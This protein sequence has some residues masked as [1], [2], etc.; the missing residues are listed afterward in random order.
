MERVPIESSK[1]PGAISSNYIFDPPTIIQIDGDRY[2]LRLHFQLYQLIE[3][4][5][6][7]LLRVSNDLF[8]TF[9]DLLH[10]RGFPEPH[11]SVNAVS[12]QP[13]HTLTVALV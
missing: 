10:V 8:I 3:T 11:H 9:V 7:T 13:F 2:G 1:L 4:T 6:A 12:V 5:H